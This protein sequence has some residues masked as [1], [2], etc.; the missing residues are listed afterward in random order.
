M[1]VKWIDK[2]KYAKHMLFVYVNIYVCLC[3]YPVCMYVCMYVCIANIWYVCTSMAFQDKTVGDNS[4]L[5]VL[6]Q[7][8]R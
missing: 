6:M 2:S 7:L 1:N 3:V 4:V 8:Y 5:A